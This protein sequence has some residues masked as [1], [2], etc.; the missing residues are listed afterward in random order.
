MKWM[1]FAP[2]LLFAKEIKPWLR[3]V[4]VFIAPSTYFVIAFLIIL[5]SSFYLS[6]NIGQQF[7]VG[8]KY[9][10]AYD[11]A[12][13]TRSYIPECDTLGAEF[14]D[15]GM[16]YEIE[17]KFRIKGGLTEMDR[18]ILSKESVSSLQWIETDSTYVYD[19]RENISNGTS[20][21]DYDIFEIEINK[22]NGIMTVKYGTT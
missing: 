18:D 14:F 12:V 1:L 11:I 2:A 22:K 3:V 19:D 8:H 16:D 15:F 10:N 21:Q 5:I 13:V 9:K 7:A 17:E 6:T 4:L 20:R